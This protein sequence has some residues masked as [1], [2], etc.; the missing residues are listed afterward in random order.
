[1]RIVRWAL[2]GLLLSSSPGVTA[3]YPWEE[4]PASRWTRDF[5]H[6]ARDNRVPLPTTQ[7]EQ[8]GIGE[9]ITVHDLFDRWVLNESVHAGRGTHFAE[10]TKDCKGKIELDFA[11]TAE[12]WQNRARQ[13]RYYRSIDRLLIKVGRRLLADFGNQLSGREKAAF[14]RALHALGWQES[15]WQH[16]IRYKNWFFVVLSGGS[17]NA[18]DDWGITQVA[19][20]HR[21]PD[22]LLNER[23]FAAKGYCSIGSTLYYGFMEYYL[24]YMAA[25]GLPCNNGAMD[26]LIGAYNQYASGFSSCH[27]EFSEDETFRTYQNRAMTGFGDHY[28]NR[29]WLRKMK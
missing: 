4:E 2:L 10:V 29:T 26:K 18:L 23:F 9:K 25:R 19:R 6:S 15:L 11:L 13:K 14:M 20:S 5:S 7:L 27:D 21:H 22:E 12:R 17:S 24:I 8:E 1:M 3:E 28:E 16:S